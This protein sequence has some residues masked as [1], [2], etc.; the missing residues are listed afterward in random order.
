MHA[1]FTQ[2]AMRDIAERPGRVARR[3]EDILAG[4]GID[5]VGARVLVVG[6]AYQPGIQ[7]VRES[8]ALEIIEALQERAAEVSYHDPLVDRVTVGGRELRSVPAPG[9]SD[10][11]VVVVVTAHPNVDYGWLSD[12]KRVLDGTYRLPGG[13]ERFTV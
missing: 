12:C 5:I 11:D 4:A 7:D 3:A 2:T 1:P 8:P 13:A 9:P 10:H 6:V